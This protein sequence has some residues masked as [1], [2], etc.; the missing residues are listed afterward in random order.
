MSLQFWRLLN[1]LLEFERSLELVAKFKDFAG[2]SIAA[3]GDLG[4]VLDFLGHWKNGTMN[5]VQVG[6]LSCVWYGS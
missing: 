5:C 2:V 6:C 1:D 3:T 4:I